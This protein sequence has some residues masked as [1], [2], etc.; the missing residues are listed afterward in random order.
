DGTVRVWDV[1]SGK[2][3]GRFGKQVDP[4]KGGWVLSVAFSPD[5]RALVS[6]G[7]DQMAHLW[8]VS[9]LTGRPRQR[10]ERSPAEL[11][12]D[13]KGLAGNAGAGYAALGRLINS[14]ERA[15][16]FL[17]KQLQSTR[18][19]DTQRIERL[20]ADLDSGRFQVREAATRELEDL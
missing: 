4:F 2:E 14:P 18:P 6:C 17:G 20:I 13:W 9:R 5:G 15:V 7:L 12:A 1:Y 16:A 10:A 11:A 19:V 8:D 3:L